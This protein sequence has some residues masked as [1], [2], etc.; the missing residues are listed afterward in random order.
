MLDVDDLRA[1]QHLLTSHIER[2]V[3]VVRLDQFAKLRRPVTLVRS[4]TLTNKL[5]SPMLS[6]RVRTNGSGVPESG[7]CAR[8]AADASFTCLIVI[9]RR[10]AHRRQYLEI[11]W[12][13]TR[14]IYRRF[15]SGFI[16]LAE[17]VR[18]AGIRIRA[19]VGIRDARQ[20]LR[21]K[22]EAVYRRARNSIRWWSVARDAPSFK[23]LRR[24]DPTTCDRTHAVIV[25]EIMTGMSRLSSSSTCR[26]ANAAAFGVQRIE[27]SFDQQ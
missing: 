4:P 9:R 5:S 22:A 2:R 17:C 1:A 12:R 18:Q 10:A 13:R 19:N 27:N 21:C 8:E 20:L 15:D 14:A 26:T 11:R 3:V 7:A 16:V 23:T 25:P 6:G 24:F